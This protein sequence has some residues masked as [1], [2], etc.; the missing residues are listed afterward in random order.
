MRYF[1]PSEFA[2]VAVIVL[3]A[4]I[5]SGRGKKIVTLWQMLGVMLPTL[6]LV[7]LVGGPNR[8]GAW[9]MLQSLAAQL[10]VQCCYTDVKFAFLLRADA[11]DRG[12]F[13]RWLPMSAPKMACAWPPAGERKPAPSALHWPPPCACRTAPTMSFLSR[14]LPCWRGNPSPPHS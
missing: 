8:A 13:C 4:R 6:P 11:A 7:G 12:D 10:A 5:I 3:L 14:R 2:K 1:Q 9:T